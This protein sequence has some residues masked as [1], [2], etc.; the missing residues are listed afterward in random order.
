MTPRI[1]TK[2][3]S[4]PLP[5]TY[6]YEPNG[7]STTTLVGGYQLDSTDTMEDQITEGYYALRKSEGFLP[8]NPMSYHQR[9]VVRSDTGK[10][11]WAVDYYGNPSYEFSYAGHVAFSAHWATSGFE[12]RDY[13]GTPPAWPDENYLLNEALASA[14]TRGFDV[15]TFMAEFRKTMSLITQF[16]KR[17]IKRAE[18]VVE[19]INR[20]N[21]GRLLTEAEYARYGY[22]RLF[23]ESWLEQRYGWRL[24]AYD[25]EGI[26]EAFYKLQQSATPFVRGYASETSTGSRTHL[27]YPLPARRI[28]AYE[29]YKNGSG[30]GFCSYLHEQEIERE[31]RAGVVLEALIDDIFVIDPLVTTFEV[32]PFSMILGWFSNID[33][34]IEAY[35]PFATENLKGGWVSY[36]TT[37]RN[38][39]IVTPLSGSA[40]NFN[41]T[42]SGT[43]QYTMETEK[44]DYSRESRDPSASLVFKV[45]LDAAKV[46]DLA[47][48][49]FGR[50]SKLLGDLQTKSNRI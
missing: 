20:R 14:R 43:T 37:Q 48:I 33:S 39:T 46:V 49:L 40:S 28:K 47:S 4:H 6:T 1:R 17:V 24:L 9:R 42:H 21:T 44:V 25:L 10:S 35:S 5:V 32:I 31:V 12:Y 7:G 36:K 38:R 50:Y 23:A 18:R 45:Q 2:I 3:N 16:R 11:T 29:R 30:S 26:T 13:G 27:A 8:I 19:G 41:Y 15:L 34:L 22:E